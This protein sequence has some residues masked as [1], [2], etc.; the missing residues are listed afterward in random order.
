MELSTDPIHIQLR[1]KTDF[2]TYEDIHRIF[3]SFSLVSW[4]ANNYKVRIHTRFIDPI[5]NLNK[6][7]F[8]FRDEDDNEKTFY[9][10]QIEKNSETFYIKLV[11]NRDEQEFIQKNIITINIRAD[12]I[13]QI[14]CIEVMD[15]SGFLS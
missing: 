9:S 15:E 14:I 11:F 7:I 8:S 3:S 10:Y 5:T 4:L 1:L 6:T 13:K 12:R 2:N